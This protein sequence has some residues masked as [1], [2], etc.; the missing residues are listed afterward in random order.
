MVYG[1][2]FLTLL[3]LIKSWNIDWNSACSGSILIREYQW[4]VCFYWIHAEYEKSTEIHVDKGFLLNLI[5][6]LEK[7]PKFKWITC[8]IIRL[9]FVSYTEMLDMWNLPWNQWI[10]YIWVIFQKIAFQLQLFA[11]GQLCGLQ[12]VFLV[13]RHRNYR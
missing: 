5:K 2:L 9:V 7:L 6:K 13:L 12:S 11:I 3:N 4:S 8:I 10:Q 1:V